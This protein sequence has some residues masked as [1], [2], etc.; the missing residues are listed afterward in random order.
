MFLLSI[1]IC[2]LYVFAFVLFS[3]LLHEQRQQGN[4]KEHFCFIVYFSI[5]QKNHK[6]FH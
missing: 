1:V 4:N 2:I 3:S 6:F 5:K